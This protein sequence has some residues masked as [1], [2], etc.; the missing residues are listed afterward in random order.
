[1]SERAHYDIVVIGSGPGGYVAAIRAVQLG[2]KVA[3]I[4]K[5]RIGG[6][7]LN[8]GCTPT[9]AII[10]CAQAF[11]QSKRATEFG[12]D[13]SSQI[14]LNFRRVMQRKDEI[15][16]TFV[17]GIEEL[18]RTHRIHVFD[19]VGTILR[20][21][22]VR[23]SRS[24]SPGAEGAELSP[25]E[26]SCR[27]IIIATGSVPAQVPIHG[28]DRPGVLNSRELLQINTLPKSMVVIGGSGIA[29]FLYTLF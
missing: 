16:D 19:G 2:A 26:L 6:T 7:C 13:I 12:I 10:W 9:K 21:G 22:L 27:S 23:V 29:P 14:K 25:Q 5:E 11:R 15:V 28:V 3:L 24:S 18:M 4:E 20:P 8:H 1:M 17:R